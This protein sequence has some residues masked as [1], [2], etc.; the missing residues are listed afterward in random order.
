MSTSACCPGKGLYGRR[1]VHQ[2]SIGKFA[3]IHELQ[4]KPITGNMTTVPLA[5]PFSKQHI[6]TG[7]GVRVR[8]HCLK[9]RVRVV[10]GKFVEGLHGVAELCCPANLQWYENGR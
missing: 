1:G 10:M 3:N 8:C 5:I 2:R 6:P 4:W 7:A 9:L